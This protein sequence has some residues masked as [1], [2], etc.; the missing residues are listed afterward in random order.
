MVWKN[1]AGT[2]D[3]PVPALG[4]VGYLAKMLNHIVLLKRKPDVVRQPEL[5]G[6]LV[7]CLRELQAKIPAIRDWKISAN[8]LRRPVSWDYVLESKFDDARALDT[9][10]QHPAYIAMVSLLRVYFDWAACDY[11]Q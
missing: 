7:Q 8:E 9:F 11:T 6:S 1:P 10:V 4:C 5:E 2:P 3:G